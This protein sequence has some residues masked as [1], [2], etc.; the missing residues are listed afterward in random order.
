MA[1]NDGPTGGHHNFIP[2]S[3]PELTV[4]GSIEI[5]TFLCERKRYLLRIKHA[6]DSGNKITPISIKYSIDKNLLLFN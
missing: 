3:H 2:I 6:N 4:L 1:P 5:H